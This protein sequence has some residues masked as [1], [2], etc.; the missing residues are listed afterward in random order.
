MEPNCSRILLGSR[1]SIG[2]Y[3]RLQSISSNAVACVSFTTPG[4]IRGEGLSDNPPTS[5]GS[6]GLPAHARI[7]R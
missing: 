6:S 1:R 4:N 7:A 3:V 2:A 5:G